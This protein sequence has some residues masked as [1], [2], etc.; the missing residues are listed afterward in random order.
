MRSTAPGTQRSSTR[1][2][3]INALDSYNIRVVT[4]TSC[5]KY[6]GQ[7]ASSQSEDR[8]VGIPSLASFALSHAFLLLH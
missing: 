1:D 5:D 8:K 4:P 6:P 3:M 7:S 2:V